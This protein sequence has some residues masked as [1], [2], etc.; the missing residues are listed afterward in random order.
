L[1][2]VAGAYAVASLP[3]EGQ[4]Q[5]LALSLGVMQAEVVP[6]HHPFAV[7]EHFHDQLLRNTATGAGRAEE[8]TGRMQPGVAEN[9]AAFRP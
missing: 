4:L 1:R 7:A 2:N 6:C 9:G 5:Y 8:T 3:N